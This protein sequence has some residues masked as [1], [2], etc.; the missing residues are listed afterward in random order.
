MP[1][2]LCSE[3]RCGNP[4]RDAGS[5][6]RCDFHYRLMERERSRSRRGDARDRN[7]MY[8]GRRWWALRREKLLQNPECELQHSG[9][10]SLAS[11][12]HHRVAMEAGGPAWEMSNL[13]S[14]CKPC[15]SRATRQEQLGRT[16]G[17]PTAA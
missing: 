17:P 2:R 3:A 12:V 10:L 8:A 16:D 1:I 4:V 7:R 15:H 9:C 14:C 6:G 5:K 13:I 11:E